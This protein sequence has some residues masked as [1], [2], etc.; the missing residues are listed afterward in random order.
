MQWIKFAKIS[1]LKMLSDKGLKAKQNADALKLGQQT[2]R[3]G[4]SK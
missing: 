3:R 2:K 4:V 1:S